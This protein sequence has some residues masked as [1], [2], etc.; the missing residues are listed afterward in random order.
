[1]AQARA[2][3]EAVVTT[4]AARYPPNMTS[5]AK[6]LTLPMWPFADEIVG[7]SRRMILVLMGAVAIVLLI[8]CVDVANLMLTRSPK[9][10]SWRRSAAPQVS[11][12]PTGPRRRC[13]RWPGIRCRVPSR[14]GSTR[15]WWASR[16]S[17]RSS[18]R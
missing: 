16:R 7:G 3:L 9:A 18:R 8:G 11:C 15:A 12:S 1:V 5:M 14:L 2:E 10:S 4:L 13:S 17:W 6:Q